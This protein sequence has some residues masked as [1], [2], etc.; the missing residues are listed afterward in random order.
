MEPKQ[1]GVSVVAKGGGPNLGEN[2]IAVLFYSTDANK[3][4][5]Q[6]HLQRFEP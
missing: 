2:D 6:L 1:L 3:E 5:V 4:Q